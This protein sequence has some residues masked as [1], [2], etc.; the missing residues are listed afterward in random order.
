[1][2]TKTETWHNCYD[3][4]WKSLITDE[5]FAHPAKYAHGLITRIILHGLSQGYWSAGDE[6]RPADL[7]GDPFGGIGTGGIVACSHGLRWLGV[8]LE[9]RFVGFAQRNFDLHKRTWETMGDPQPV[10]VQ[11]D[12]R[13]FAEIVGQC[14]AVVTSPPYGEDVIHAR[15]SKMAVEL[16]QGRQCATGLGQYGETPGQIGSLPAGE[17]QAVVTSPPYAESNQ[18]YQAGMKT[19]ANPQSITAGSKMPTAHYGG[20]PG[21]I[22]Q[23]PSGNLNAIVTSP[24]YAESV[25]GEHGETETAA[26]SQA[27]RQTPGGST[28]RSQR[29]GGYGVADG[30]VG[31]LAEGQLQAVVTSPPYEKSLDTHGDG[32]DWQKACNGKG[33]RTAGRAAIADGYQGNSGNIGHQAGETY[34]HAMRTIYEQCRLALRPGGY[35]VVVIKDYVKDG[36]RVPLCD[37]TVQLLEHLGFD[38]FLRVHAM[39]VKEEVNAGLFGEH[40]RK[41]ERKSFFRRLHEKKPGAVRIDWEEV[42]WARAPCSR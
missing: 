24:P 42:L 27:K 28:G 8:E 35:L 6:S 21:Q 7:I 25:K 29:H 32:I 9:P 22:G 40:R 37:Q 31:A 23:L 12:S 26:E 2:S 4:S 14:A 33:S 20:T 30:Q 10:L 39:L 17:L 1:M 15:P 13:R 38:V 34:W 41:K 5:S 19:I 11:G 3:G 18:D 16:H 36:K